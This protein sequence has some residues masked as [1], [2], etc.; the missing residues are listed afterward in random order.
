MSE[1]PGTWSY[2][3]GSWFGVFGA[4]TTLLLPAS[5]KPRVGDLWSRIDDGAGFDDILDALVQS[6]LG[7]LSGFVL[8]STGEGPTKILVRGATVRATVTVGE[9]TSELDGSTVTTWVERMFP[10]VTALSVVVDGDD[11]GQTAGE[12]GGTPGTE[13]LPIHDGLVRVGRIDLPPYAPS[14]AEPA[15]TA[16]PDSSLAGGYGEQSA[17]AP[18][19]PAEEPA[20]AAA[21][22]LGPPPTSPPP[23]SPPPASPPSAWSPEADALPEPDTIIPEPA[24]SLEK[25]ADE[26][27]QESAAAPAETPDAASD[28]EAA[29][30][31]NHWDDDPLGA[32]MGDSPE[33][34]ESPESADPMDEESSPLDDEPDTGSMTPEADAGSDQASAASPFAPAP[35]M[36]VPPSPPSPPAWP[37]GSPLPP[38][39]P[40]APPGAPPTEIGGVPPE[41]DEF[42]DHDEPG[43]HGTDND[44]MTQAGVDVGEFARPQPGIPG[45][46][47][48]PSV[49][50]SVAKLVISNGET[51]DVDRV[52]LIGRAPEARRFTSTDQPLLVTVP[53]PLHEIS[54]TH[55]EFRP[56]SG[57]DHGSA[58]V[59]D[60]GSTNGTVLV[61]PGLSAEELKPGIS[62]QVLPGAIVNLGDGVTIQV[63][64]P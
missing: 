62:V 51:V 28:A 13:D 44:G 1:Q 29:A 61:Q 23:S 19:T 11:A 41:H 20:P 60:M 52:V 42:G 64:H 47:M 16:M 36:P 18:E 8:V 45:Q 50:P 9:E 24:F 63:T 34:S 40:Y 37:G 22:P 59:T 49:G 14:S 6:G 26:P 27:A 46:Q 32:M 5:E 43:G 2:R 15:S 12:G 4:A 48:A 53:S 17:D 10:E 30:E 58:V 56:G 35:P 25:Q 3:P 33:S 54:S 55:V 7:V 21:A 39:P 57:A 31:S 38:P